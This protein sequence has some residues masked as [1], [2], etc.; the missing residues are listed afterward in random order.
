MATAKKKTT[1]TKAAVKKTARKPVKRKTTARAVSKTKKPA[2]KKR[3]AKK[4]TGSCFVLTPFKEP[5]DGYYATIIEPAITS[6]NLEPKRGDSIFRPSP[7]MADVWQMIRDATVLLAVLTGK[8]PNVFYELGLAHAIGKA[9]ILVSET[10]DDVPFDLQSLRIIKYE[11]D[12]PNWGLKLRRSISAA[13][14]ETVEEPVQAVPSMFLKKVKSQAPAESDLVARVGAIERKLASLPTSR[15][16]IVSLS[17][18]ATVSRLISRLS[19]VKEESAVES[20]AYE[21]LANGMDLRNIYE[22]LVT[23][24]SSKEAFRIIDS[25]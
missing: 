24:I 19:D 20:L 12:D 22:A 16:H 2:K 15:T 7:I 1:R 23:R 25:L 8:N 14:E 4:P 10:L 6:A 17:R 9:V 3:V 5:F 11:K 13:L 18:D 21:A